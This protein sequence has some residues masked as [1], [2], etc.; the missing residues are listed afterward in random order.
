M[1]KLFEFHATI[2]TFLKSFD[3]RGKLNSQVKIQTNWK[4][5]VGSLNLTSRLTCG[6]ILRRNP[7]K[8]KSSRFSTDLQTKFT[9]L[10]LQCKWI[11]AAIV[12][13]CPDINI[14]YCVFI[15]VSMSKLKNSTY[16]QL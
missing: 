5:L 11:F 6:Y 16:K 9:H 4:H 10:G 14:E 12:R 7:Q 13:N 8:I 3:T 15:T 1:A 2:S